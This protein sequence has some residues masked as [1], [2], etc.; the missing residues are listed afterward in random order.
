M[1]QKRA[2]ELRKSGR[3]LTLDTTYS[4]EMCKHWIPFWKI[5][6]FVKL[7]CWCNDSIDTDT[8]KPPLPIAPPKA[9]VVKEPASLE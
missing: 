1:C 3:V 8:P 6:M 4:F 9:F 7:K 5:H 2:C